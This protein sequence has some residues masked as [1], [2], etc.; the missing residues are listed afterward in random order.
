MH[1]RAAPRGKVAIERKLCDLDRPVEV[2]HSE[3]DLATGPLDAHVVPGRHTYGVAQ[4]VGFLDGLLGGLGVRGAE[5]QVTEARQ[6]RHSRRRRSRQ[7]CDVQ[8]QLLDAAQ[9]VLGGGVVTADGVRELLRDLGFD[10]GQHRDERAHVCQLEAHVA[11]PGAVERVPGTKALNE[12]TRQSR[13]D[14]TR[15]AFRVEEVAAVVLHGLQ[16]PV[17]GAVRCEVRDQEGMIDQRPNQLRNVARVEIIVGDRR[18][19]GLTRE[20]SAEHRQTTKR[21]LLVLIEQPVAP[22]EKRGHRSLSF[23]QVSVAGAEQSQTVVEPLED[24][25]DVEDR[26]AGGRDLQ[27][28]WQPVQPLADV[29]DHLVRLIR[30]LEVDAS[31]P[32]AVDKEL[33]R[34][35][36]RQGR[37]SNDDL[38]ADAEGPS[39]RR[40]DADARADRDELSRERRG[41]LEVALRVVEQDEGRARSKVIE[42][43]GPS[44]SGHA[45]PVNADRVRDGVCDEDRVLDFCEIDEPDSIGPGGRDLDADLHCDAASFPHHRVLPT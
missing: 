21:R 16:E 37:D 6:H 25:V 9:D 22:V 7:L 42:H 23:G 18:A 12:P 40:E 3:G 1:I 2:V 24:L 28:E 14:L 39:A 32:C 43:I 15:R 26:N 11:D 34:D 33:R 10:V 17:P 31:R 13:R 5:L 20:T 4:P 29:R 8:A 30:D 45:L 38:P 36:D 41:S 19:R 44:V 35:G 27:R